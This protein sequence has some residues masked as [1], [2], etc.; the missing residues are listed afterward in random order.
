MG[1]AR[2]GDHVDIPVGSLMDKMVAK[3]MSMSSFPSAHRV[4]L[5]SQS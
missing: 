4:R 5:R 3:I 2:K 1:V